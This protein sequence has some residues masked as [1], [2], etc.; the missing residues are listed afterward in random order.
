MNK[1]YGNKELHELIT[2]QINSDSL[3][4]SYLFYGKKGIGKRT[5]CRYIA[6]G[7]F[8][9]GEHKPCNAC[10]SCKK[11][12]GDNHPDIYFLDAKDAK[13][14]IHIDEIRA[15]RQDAYIS[16]N[17]S[18]YKVYIIPNVENMS[19]GAF[20]ALL[21]VLEEPPRTAMFLLTATSKSAVPET[22]LSRCLSYS[23]YE[24]PDDECIEAVADIF[25]GIDEDKRKQAALNANGV[26][27]RAI[28]SLSNDDALAVSNVCNALVDGL[29]RADEYKALAS[30]TDIKAD[31]VM[32]NRLLDE[33]VATIRSSLLY[34]L[35]VK[36]DATERQRALANIL[37]E[38]KA[39]RM[40]A[41][42]QK[43]GNLNDGNASVSLLLSWL[44]A[45]LFSVI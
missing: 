40:L 22:I 44:P 11:F 32:L 2:R 28:E 8:C 37:T 42:I 20:N 35:K 30:L 16:P 18:A 33:L 21:K 36:T 19:I 41:V 4:H 34:K 24:L 17:E 9:K 13:N 38:K 14:S 1:F 3:C 7:V 5:F 39:E 25:P 27:G 31:R 23:L 43:A 29:V 6:K 26:L 15:I 12:D 45:N 10:S